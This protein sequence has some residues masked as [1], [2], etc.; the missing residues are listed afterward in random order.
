VQPAVVTLLGTVALLSTLLMLRIITRGRAWTRVALWA[1][2]GMVGAATAWVMASALL[3]AAA[4][5][6]TTRWCALVGFGVGG[7]LAVV[8]SKAAQRWRTADRR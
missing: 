3:G 4:T 8:A 7:G 2:W 5:E 6:T 1:G